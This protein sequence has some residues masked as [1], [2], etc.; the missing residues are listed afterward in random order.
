MKRKIKEIGGNEI[1]EWHDRVTESMEMKYQFY[2]ENIWTEANYDNVL[3]IIFLGFRI[4][5]QEFGLCMFNFVIGVKEK[6]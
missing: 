4:G 1:V 6:C 5:K 3:P 2:F